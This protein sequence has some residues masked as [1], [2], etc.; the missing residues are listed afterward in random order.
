VVHQH[1]PQRQIVA[2]SESAGEAIEVFKMLLRRVLYTGP[3][4]VRRVGG[5]DRTH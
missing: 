4:L 5:G 1:A 3:L 2:R